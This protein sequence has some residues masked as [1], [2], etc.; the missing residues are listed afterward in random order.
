MSPRCA[1]FDCCK[2]LL[3]RG[4][5]V[6]F[7]P[8]TLQFIILVVDSTDRERLAISKEELYRMLAHEV[9]SSHI[10]VRPWG[11]SLHTTD[12]FHNGHWFFFY[13][14][15]PIL[16]RYV[17]YGLIVLWPPLRTCGKQ[18]CWY[19]PISRIWRTVCLQQRSPNTSPW[20]PSKTT[21]GT[22]SPAVHLQER[23]KTY[24][25]TWGHHQYT[26]VLKMISLNVLQGIFNTDLLLYLACIS[27]QDRLCL[28]TC[29]IPKYDNITRECWTS[30]HAAECTHGCVNSNTNSRAEKQREM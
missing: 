24:M 15:Q 30:G 1:A 11:N 18:L 7:L 28:H 27:K 16:P 13:Q 6:W 23:G 14:G 12:C 10:S 21:P 20:A 25:L 8:P 22:Y 3:K 29:L 26:H 4:H 5:S 2:C 17:V 19:L 9:T